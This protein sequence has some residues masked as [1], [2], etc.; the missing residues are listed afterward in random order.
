[1]SKI[2][3]K[4]PVSF[5]NAS[6]TSLLILIPI[7]LANLIVIE[8]VP[9]QYLSIYYHFVYGVFYFSIGNI[10]IYLFCEHLPSN[11]FISSVIILVFLSSLIIIFNIYIFENYLRMFLSLTLFLLGASYGIYR[12]KKYFDER[13]IEF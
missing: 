1:M 4:W 11:R 3:W 10:F 7:F 9:N 6:A 13:M 12:S 2:W 5:F 8:Y